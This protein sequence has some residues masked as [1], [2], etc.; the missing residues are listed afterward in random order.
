MIGDDDDELYN[1]AVALAVAQGKLSTS[2]L[3]RK[4]RIGYAR[5]ARLMD[6]LEE[7]SVISPYV[8]GQ[9]VRTVLPSSMHR[10]HMREHA[11]R[12]DK[13]LA[14]DGSIGKW[15]PALRWILFLP[16]AVIY[17]ALLAVVVMGGNNYVLHQP[18]G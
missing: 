1:N 10:A 4:F 15:S 2:M 14:A 8:E 11:R 16:A 5:A 3:Q 17:P 6:L 12:P 13:D 18:S 9:L 7:H